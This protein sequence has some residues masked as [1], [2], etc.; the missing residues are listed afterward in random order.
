MNTQNLSN[1]QVFQ[2]FSHQLQMS[3][4]SVWPIRVYPDPLPMD[5]KSAQRKPARHKKKSRGKV[6]K[7]GSSIVSTTYN[8]EAMKRHSGVR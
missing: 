1:L 2:S 6:S 4:P 8:L 7:Q 3:F 5:N